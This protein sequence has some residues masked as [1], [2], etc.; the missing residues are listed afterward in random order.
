M[1]A[2]EVSTWKECIKKN[3]TRKVRLKNIDDYI[4]N[5]DGTFQFS[6]CDLTK[7]CSK[8]IK[9]LA[10][11]CTESGLSSAIYVDIE[12]IR[13]YGL[14][15]CL[16]EENGTVSVFYAVHAL[17]LEVSRQQSQPEL[18]IKSEL[19][20]SEIERQIATETLARSA[21]ETLS[22]MG[23]HLSLSGKSGIIIC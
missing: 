22:E 5:L 12:N 8:I 18:K 17:A 6:A 19:Q 23:I 13:V 21:I 1:S 11:K 10:S 15:H 4:K 9:E 16:L 7:E 20:K 2:V 3:K 14:F